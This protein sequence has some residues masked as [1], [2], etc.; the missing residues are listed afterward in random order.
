MAF[1]RVS[2]FTDMHTEREWFGT[3]SLCITLKE[4]PIRET[5]RPARSEST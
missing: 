1:G 2:A 5:K 3:G 4:Q